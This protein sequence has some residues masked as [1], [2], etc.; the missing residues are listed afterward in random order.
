MCH[1]VFG[2]ALPTDPAGKKAIAK[3]RN[4]SHSSNGYL[5]VAL[6]H[7]NRDESFLK[8][9]QHTVAIVIASFLLNAAELGGKVG[10]KWRL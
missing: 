10:N 6:L 1:A 5:C 7:L 8:A 3:S 9:C 2:D 4:R